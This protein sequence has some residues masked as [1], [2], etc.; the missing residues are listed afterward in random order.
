MQTN[1]FLHANAIDSN[2]IADVYRNLN[3]FGKKSQNTYT[4]KK[5]YKSNIFFYSTLTLICK[6]KR[7]RFT[8]T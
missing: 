6:Y 1:M 8:G 7:K 4:R 2:L 3:L 5:H